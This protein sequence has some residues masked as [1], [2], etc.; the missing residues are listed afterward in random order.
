MV[1]AA[2]LWS[3]LFDLGHS[4]WFDELYF[5]GHFVREGPSEILAGPDLSHELYGLLAWAAAT[6]VGESETAFRL[7][8]AL[9]FVAGVFAV[10]AWLHVRVH[11]LAG[12]LYLFL[13]T[14]SPLLLDIS[15]QARGYGLAY[16]AMSVLIVAALE[17]DRSGRA[18]VVA[19]ACTAGV[20]GTWTLPQFGIGFVATSSVLLADRKLRKPTLVGLLASGVAIAAWYAPHVGQVRAA[21]QVEAGFRISTTWLITA[22]IDQ[23]LI[24]ALVWIEGVAL[25]PG[26]IWLPLVVLA[27]LIMGSS[28][29]LRQR[30]SALIL[31]SGL[32]AMVLVLWAIQAHI[33]T[34][35][36]SYLLVPSFMLVASGASSIVLRRPPERPAIFRGL[37]CLVAIL[38]LGVRF[39]TIAPDVVRLPREANRDAAEIIEQRSARGTPIFVYTLLPEGL[40]FYLDRPF[41]ALTERTVVRRVCSAARPAV[42]VMQPMA[43]DLVDV[44]CLTRPGVELHRIRQYARGGEI[45]VWF[46][47]PGT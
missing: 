9:P 21:S 2:L 26:A 31:C 14:V 47:P 15:R 40:A 6:L 43:I 13:S 12:W 4:F 16:L 39:L 30:Q 20:V 3:R 45:D 44:P 17:A 8:S 11:A 33:F 46:V 24:P 23:I 35:Y 34:R 5:V 27:V 1:G 25:I 18:R 37:V 7:L 19:L 38:V 10:A 41:V 42:Y 22:P 29:L 32:V 36:L 28:P